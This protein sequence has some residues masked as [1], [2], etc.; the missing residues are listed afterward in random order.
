MQ[1]ADLHGR[2]NV[3]SRKVPT[4]QA[5]WSARAPYITARSVAL[6]KLAGVRTSLAL[7]ALRAFHS[8]S[9]CFWVG[10]GRKGQESTNG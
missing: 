10:A 7:T 4:N 3:Q 6:V 8:P 2:D 5:P 9:I 1:M